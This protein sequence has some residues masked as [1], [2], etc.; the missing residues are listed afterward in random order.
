MGPLEQQIQGEVKTWRKTLG[1]ILPQAKHWA[2]K[3]WEDLSPLEKKE[4]YLWFWEERLSSSSSSSS[5]SKK[6]KKKKENKNEKRLDKL[7]QR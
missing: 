4:C 5:S 6:K 3:D 7:R 1:R 2:A